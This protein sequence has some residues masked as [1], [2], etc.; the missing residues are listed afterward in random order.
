MCK[1]FQYPIIDWVRLAVKRVKET[2]SK[3]IFWL[4]E[5]RPHDS[6]IIDIVKGDLAYDE[7]DLTGVDIEILS[8]VD[9]MMVSC[10]RS[11]KGKNTIS[12]ILN[13]K[14]TMSTKQLF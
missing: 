14:E 7:I 11:R 9:A 2:G 6:N 1:S 8:P 3:G 4:D 12:E 5:N 10:E 13:G